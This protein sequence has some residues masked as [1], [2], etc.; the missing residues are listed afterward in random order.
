MGWARYRKFCFSY[1]SFGAL[2]RGRQAQGLWVEAPRGKTQ[3]LTNHSESSALP[4]P[5]HGSSVGT[6]RSH[7]R[8]GTPCPL[9]QPGWA[10]QPSAPEQPDPAPRRSRWAQ[11]NMPSSDA[12]PW[13]PVAPGG[14]DPCR[15]RGHLHR[16]STSRLEFQ[17]LGT[18]TLTQGPRTVM[19]W[20]KMALHPLHRS[21]S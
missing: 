6:D 4:V 1:R 19:V 5:R 10:H 17:E 13:D 7:Q 12:V 2:Q 8:T 3:A 11:K 16:A 9:P 15:A 21:V 20:G 18:H 14:P